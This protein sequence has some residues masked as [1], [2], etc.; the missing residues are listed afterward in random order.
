MS[1]ES[2]AEHASTSP[3][4]AT[5]SRAGPVDST[6]RQHGSG[7]SIHHEYK[8]PHTTTHSDVA[9]QQQQMQQQH[10]QQ[11]TP[12]QWY[13]THGYAN[14]TPPYVAFGPHAS[15]PAAA[16]GGY[17]DSASQ[18]WYQPPAPPLQQ[19]FFANTPQYHATAPGLATASS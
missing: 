19:Q 7:S 10:Q 12:G 16:Y 15:A 9:H 6:H 1:M 4:A 11:H 14:G 5:E 13:D 8:S 2:M 17:F 3:H 18:Q